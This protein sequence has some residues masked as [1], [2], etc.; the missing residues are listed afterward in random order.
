[1]ALS[2]QLRHEPV[3][4]RQH[5]RIDVCAVD[6]GIGHD[7]D[8]VIAKFRDVEVIMNAAAEGRDHRLNLGVCIDPVLTRLLDVQDLAAKGQDGLCCS[9]SCALC[10]PACGVSLDEEDLTVLRILVRAVR[11]LSG[12]GHGLERGLSSGKI[13]GLACSLPGALGELCLLADRLCNH[14]VLLEVIRQFLRY[15]RIDGASCLKVS[16][17]LL[18]LSLELGI[19]DLDGDDGGKALSQ[20]IAGQVR[21]G[22]LQDPGLSCIVV[23]GLRHGVVEAHHVHAALGGV[24]VVDEGIL[25]DVVGIVVLHRDLDVDVVLRP[26]KVHDVLVERGL[27]AV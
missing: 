2:Y 19:L 11:K 18:C 4:E 20:I 16:E 26:V 5:Q 10:R 22:V 1:M 27:A 15:H 23:E 12:K 17:L 3:Q 8:L 9:R 7:D 25:R 21:V 14:R 6:I 13:S 24:D